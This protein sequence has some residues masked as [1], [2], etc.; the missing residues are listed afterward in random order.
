MISEPITN[1]PRYT[2]SNVNGSTLP[3]L[4]VDVERV[5]LAVTEK[6]IGGSKTLSERLGF[7]AAESESGSSLQVVVIPE[8]DIEFT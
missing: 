7:S 5:T 6:Q 1:I 2:L 4:K 8:F 3:K